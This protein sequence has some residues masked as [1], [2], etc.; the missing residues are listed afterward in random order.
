M[1]LC[2]NFVYGFVGFEGNDKFV[3]KVICELNIGI[4]FLYNEMLFVYVLYKDFFDII[5]V[6]VCEN[7]GVV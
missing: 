4:V 6:V 1:L 2:V 5:K 7:G 3:I